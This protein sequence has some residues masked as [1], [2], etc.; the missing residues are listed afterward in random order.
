VEVGVRDEIVG[1][2]VVREG[3]AGTGVPGESHRQLRTA[4]AHSRSVRASA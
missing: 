4:H 1:R 2:E 3:R